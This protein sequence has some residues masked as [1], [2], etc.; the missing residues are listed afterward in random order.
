[1][2]TDFNV[3]GYYME[4][5]SLDQEWSAFNS[6]SASFS[7]NEILVISWNEINM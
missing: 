1:M 2:F 3:N 4:T 5:S 7:L 6:M